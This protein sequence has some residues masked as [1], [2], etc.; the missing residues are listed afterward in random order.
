MVEAY[1]MNEGVSL[2]IHMGWNR[3][4][5]ELD[6]T[7]VLEACSGGDAWSSEPASIYAECVDNVGYA[8]SVS[9]KHVEANKVAH[10]L[11]KN[12]LQLLVIGSMNSLLL[13]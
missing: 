4:I 5:A 12:S 13:F 8:G 1:A 3:I 7:E 9:F 2:A 6:C 10:E 11:A